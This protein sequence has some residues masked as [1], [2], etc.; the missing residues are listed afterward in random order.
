MAT[1]TFST[2]ARNAKADAQCALVDGGTLRLRAG[3]TVLAN[4]T[5][6]NPAFGSAA[7]GV[8]E[9]VGGDGE[10][11][12][13]VGNPL[14]GVGL[15]AAGTGTA[16]DNA[17]YLTSG[18]QVRWEGDAGVAGSGAEG[19]DP[20]V[21]LVNASIAEDQPIQVTGISYTEPATVIS[22]IPEP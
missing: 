12:I 17:Q 11:P 22:G 9:A 15:P 7:S 20:M 18:G 4:I 16:C 5:L 2:E 1:T 13:G 8:A 21:V 14:T 10:S 19:S 3:T 6:Q